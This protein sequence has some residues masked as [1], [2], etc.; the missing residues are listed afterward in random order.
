[1]KTNC[2]CSAILNANSIR[3]N[4]DKQSRNEKSLTINVYYQK[5]PL[6]LLTPGQTDDN[7]FEWV[8][9]GLTIIGDGLLTD[10]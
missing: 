5:R 2:R 10:L 9:K 3:V 1:M 6:F 4:I 8:V 7:V